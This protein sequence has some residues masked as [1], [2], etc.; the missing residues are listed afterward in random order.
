MPARAY[1]HCSRQDGG[2][3]VQNFSDAPGK[4]KVGSLQLHLVKVGF[5]QL[6]LN[7]RG[8]LQLD[9]WAFRSIHSLFVYSLVRSL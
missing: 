6:R 2:A 8:F 9:N 3:S 5:L 4:P 1:D 7:E